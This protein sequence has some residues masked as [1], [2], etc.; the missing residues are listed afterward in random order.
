VRTISLPIWWQ[1]YAI[2]GNRYDLGHK[3]AQIGEKLF[4]VRI[5]LM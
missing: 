5:R 4:V 3:T 2:H 1:P